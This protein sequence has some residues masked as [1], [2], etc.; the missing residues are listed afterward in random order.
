MEIKTGYGYVSIAKAVKEL[1]NKDYIPYFLQ[2]I[3]IDKKGLL[4]EFREFEKKVI[5]AYE[6]LE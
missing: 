6:K 1:E 4:N 3:Y 2:S 5:E